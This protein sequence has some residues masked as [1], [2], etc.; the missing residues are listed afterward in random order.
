MSN[1]NFV[2]A[3]RSQLTNAG[4]R[5]TEHLIN[6]LNKDVKLGIIGEVVGEEQMPSYKMIAAEISSSKNVMVKAH[7]EEK[8]SLCDILVEKGVLK[9]P[10]KCDPEY[11]K[12]ESNI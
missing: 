11:F 10:Y 7:D 6:E 3:K 5:I 1:E 4:R 2:I 9:Q 12:Y 8:K